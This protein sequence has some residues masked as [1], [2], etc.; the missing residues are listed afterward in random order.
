MLFQQLLCL[1]LQS[2]SLLALRSRYHDLLKRHQI[3]EAT[4]QMLLPSDEW[5]YTNQSTKF[6]QFVKH[7]AARIL[8]Y[9]G[10][11]DRV[12]SRVNVFNFPGKNEQ[13]ES[14]EIN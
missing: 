7:H 2:V 10:L 11:G 12:G 8:V 1:V 4:I 5:Y 14:I 13:I 6:A 9:I 3:E